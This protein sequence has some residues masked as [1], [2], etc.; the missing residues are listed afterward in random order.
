MALALLALLFV[1]LEADNL[2]HARINF[3]NNGT[4]HQQTIDI[5]KHDLGIIRIKTYSR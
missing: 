5:S 3:C 4:S 1:V 2:E